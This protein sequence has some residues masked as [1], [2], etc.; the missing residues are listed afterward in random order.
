M[1]IDISGLKGIVGLNKNTIKKYIQEQEDE[2]R[3]FGKRC[4]KEYKDLFTGK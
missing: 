2:D 3:L 1:E 4:L